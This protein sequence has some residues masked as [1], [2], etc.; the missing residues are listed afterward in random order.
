MLVF[1]MAG[2]FSID[3]KLVSRIVI[4]LFLVFILLFVLT[5]ANRVK[6]KSIPGWCSVYYAVRG[7]PEVLIV[8]GEEGL[9]DPD[10]LADSLRN[11]NLAGVSSSLIRLDSVNPG[12][13]KKYQLVIVTKA[14]KMS[15]AKIKMFLDYAATGGNLVWTGDAGAETEKDDDL[16]RESEYSGD[17]N[18]NAAINPWAR[19]H[20]GYVVMLNK[21]ISA[22]YITNYCSIKRCSV[23]EPY[24]AG[25]LTP[26]S[27]DNPLVYGFG[28][29]QL[30]V[31]EGEDFAIVEPL[32]EGTSTTIM[33][34]DFGSNL[35]SGEKNYGNHLPMITSNADASILGQKIGENIFYYAMPP[36]YYVNPKVPA[37]KHYGLVIKDMYYGILYG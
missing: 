28:P 12:N 3:M 14:R 37:E 25:L 19:K 31:T 29:L 26:I 30:Q 24:Y 7:K 2:S 27:R 9:G 34:I 22:N 18:S 35:I 8:Y 32:S 5:L 21:A 33:T 4:L 23:E 10:L 16:L 20:E 6:C 15:A 36:E 11:P 13:L 1:A 17:S